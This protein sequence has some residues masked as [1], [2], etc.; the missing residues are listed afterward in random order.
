MKQFC[1]YIL[2]LIC[3]FQSWSQQQKTDSTDVKVGLVLSGGGAKGLAHI[4]ALKIIDSLGIRLDYITG[5]SMGAIVGGLY[6]S[7]YNAKQLD[8]L[9]HEVDFS[10]L[11][12]D[13]IPRKAKTFYEKDY[14]EKYALTLPI[15]KGK[16]SLP[17]GISNG[18]NFYN[19]YSEITAHVK[20]INDFS[21]L[22]IPFFC[23]GTDIETGEGLI[24]D[25]GYLPDVIAASSALPTVYS[26]IK[27]N[28]KLV[29]DGGVTN[30][31]P[32]EEIKKRGAEIVIGVDVQDT[33][34]NREQLITVADI[35][36][37][38]SN[39][40]TINDM[41]VKAPLT[42]IYIKPDIERFSVV[43]FNDGQEIIK[44]GEKSARK[45]LSDF[46]KI[47]S[48]QKKEKNISKRVNPLKKINLTG[49]S[50]N[51]KVNYTRSY[52]KSK[53]HINFPSTIEI[54]KLTNGLNNLYSTGNF[55]RIHY[56]I[57]TDE[58]RGNTLSLDVEESTNKRFIRFGLRYDNLYKSAAILNYTH[59]NFITKN[60]VL[61]GDF[62]LSDQFR[63]N[64]DYYIDQGNHWS[65]GISHHL[66][67]YDRN[68]DFSFVRDRRGLPDIP[69]NFIDI[70]Y[71][72]I[73]SQFYLETILKHSFAFRI[74]FEHKFLEIKTNTFA[75]EIPGSVFD[76]INYYSILSSIRYDSFNDKY[77]PSKGIKFDASFS[78][79]PF[80]SES[81]QQFEEFGIAKSKLAYAQKISPKISSVISAEAGLRLGSSSGINSLDFFLGG[82][83]S[84]EINNQVSFLGYDFLQISGDSYIKSTLMLDY[85]FI[86]KHHVN[87]TANFSNVGNRIF[88]FKQWI[89]L[90]G[91]S[92]Y[93][94]GYGY[95]SIIGPIQAKYA[96]S[97]DDNTID[98]FFVSVGYWF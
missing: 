26:P 75:E 44:E 8:S 5:S 57:N 37:Q 77:F 1:F 45:K 15:I 51:N 59:K 40:K 65:V 76:K 97:P 28:G 52:I 11:I 78:G 92:G 42:D 80:S 9:F 27:Y 96:F 49:L 50:I 13:R 35:M 58:D 4:G 47:A 14:S 55:E 66:N 91:F 98:Q 20:D 41:K 17:K 95:N 89:Q 2:S 7:G 3:F 36:L 10:D 25:K 88:D 19:F 81:P 38:I 24:F 60:D 39:F 74:G 33:L 43:G 61:S 63:Y 6:A 34:L 68:V 29:T 71:L 82:Y 90:D 79:Y 84:I 94:I 48:T 53:L 73:T 21:K 87:F 32:I 18:Q 67:Q 69:I 86:K 16:L 22:P 85:E 83:G 54:K 31:Y 12:Q 23:T 30:N 93:G 56:K 46:Q 72:D 64:L 62:I 70:D